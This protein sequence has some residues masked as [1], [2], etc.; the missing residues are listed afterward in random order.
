MN[1]SPKYDSNYPTKAWI[2]T[3]KPWQNTQQ[4]NPTI[5]RT[6]GQQ[7]TTTTESSPLES[8]FPVF[9]RNT[10]TVHWPPP[11]PSARM[12]RSS[13]TEPTPPLNTTAVALRNTP[14]GYIVPLGFSARSP[15]IPDSRN[16]A[17][18]KWS[19]SREQFQTKI[20]QYYIKLEA[21]NM[22][23]QTINDHTTLGKRSRWNPTNYIQGIGQIT[24]NFRISNTKNIIYRI[25]E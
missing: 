5:I 9:M 14:A 11:H 2:N 7:Q 19:N 25:G 24:R 23:I 17:D 4:N 21:K 13:T 8:K 6:K 3:P 20:H 15:T 18:T 10:S 16:K 1:Q 12:R 22:E